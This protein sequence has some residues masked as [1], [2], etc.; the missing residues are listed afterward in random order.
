MTP[1]ARHMK[2]RSC[3]SGCW[4]IGAPEP[5]IDEELRNWWPQKGAKRHKKKSMREHGKTKLLRAIACV[6]FAL[7]PLLLSSCGTFFGS[8][9]SGS[10]GAAQQS[11]KAQ[12][13]GGQQAAKAQPIVVPQQ[14]P[15]A[16]AA[17]PPR[18]AP[19]P[20]IS[21]ETLRK[22]LM[23]VDLAFSRACEERGAPEAFYDFMAA[24]GVC[25]LSG[26][27]PVQGRDAIKVRFAA[28]PTEAISWKP[29][30]AEIGADSNLGYTWGMYQF[31]TATGDKQN[32]AN[33]KYVIVWKKQADGEWKAA[34]F[35]TSAGPVQRS[36]E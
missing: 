2:I 30:E 33:G 25:L 6:N 31:R 19:V 7:V 12:A 3:I 8:N 16:Q 9:G 5:E 17:E 14:T 10:N 32:S 34:V 24:D 23:G 21:S 4:S 26:E 18:V 13:A 22:I 1:G 15:K 35:I 29:R 28:S 20:Q 27:Q 36:Q 11:P